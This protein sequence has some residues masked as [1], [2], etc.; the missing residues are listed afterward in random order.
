V[1]VIEQVY[2]EA[3]F[4]E[5]QLAA[6][7]DCIAS[8]QRMYILS[9]SRCVMNKV[10]RGR[11]LPVCNPL[12]D[13]KSSERRASCRTEG[14]AI[15]LLCRPNV[16]RSGTSPALA[17]KDHC[18]DRQAGQSATSPYK[19]PVLQPPRLYGGHC[20]AGEVSLRPTNSP[21]S[22]RPVCMEGTARRA[23]CHFALQTARHPAAPSVWRA[24]QGGRSATS[25]YK[26]P[27]LQPPCLYGGHC[28]QG[29]MVLRL[30]NSPSYSH[31]GCME[32]TARRA[33]CH[34]ALQTSRPPAAP[35]EGT[36]GEVSLRPTATLPCDTDPTSSCT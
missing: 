25:P 16:G 2:R 14:L 28:K 29:E 3:Q 24:L 9:P 22:S 31:P 32:G 5:Q 15:Y 30:T 10:C 36:P 11:S 21:S 23:K 12:R 8:C 35:P 7:A 17:P 6:I 26:Q 4:V 18:P 19:Q 13:Q 27:V 20:K 1:Y 33:K 34:F